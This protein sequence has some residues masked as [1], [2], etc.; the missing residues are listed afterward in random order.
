MYHDA[1][2]DTY[3]IPKSSEMEGTVH[4]SIRGALVTWQEAG[5]I[6]EERLILAHGWNV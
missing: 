4:F 2:A 1:S 5:D 6:R 3:M